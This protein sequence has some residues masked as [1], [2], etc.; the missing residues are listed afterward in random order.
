MTTP[1]SAGDYRRDDRCNDDLGDDGYEAGDEKGTQPP[2]I[3]RRAGTMRTLPA[4]AFGAGEIDGGTSG[5]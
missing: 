3:K 1:V 5:H 2:T 4:D